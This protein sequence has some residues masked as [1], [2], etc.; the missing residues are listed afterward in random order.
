MKREMLAEGVT[1]Y[2]G[3][4]RDVLPTIGKVDAVISD[5][6]YGIGA[7]NMSLGKWA[8]SRVAK[9]DWDTVAPDLTQIT[10][11]NVPTIIWGGNYFDLPPS[12]CFL[13]WNKG[14]GFK[15]R[16][17]AECEVAWTNVDAVA[18]L[19]THDPLAA[20]DYRNKEHKTQKPVPVMTWCLQQIPNARLILDPYMGSGTTGVAAVKLGRRFIGI[21][22][23]PAYFDIACRRVDHALREPDMFIDKPKPL[24]QEAML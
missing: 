3:D 12:R 18:R 19:L 17:F 8:A 22:I 5:P 10:V 15:G 1:L 14:A 13:V 20:G 2:L 7:S 4:C 6:P 24:K 9:S 23:E 11:L 21:E 16:D